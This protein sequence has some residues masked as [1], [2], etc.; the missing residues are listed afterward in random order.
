MKVYYTNPRM[1]KA[2]YILASMSP[3]MVSDVIDLVNTRGRSVI[4]DLADGEGPIKP[5]A[6]FSREYIPDE[7]FPQIFLGMGAIY[8][9][10]LRRL[11]QDNDFYENVL[12][13]TFFIPEDMAAALARKVETID[14]IGGDPKV[15]TVGT[16][17]KLSDALQETIRKAINLVPSILGTNWENDQD[18]QYD[19][20][21]LYEVKTFGT[22]IDDL[23]TRAHLMKSQA[24]LAKS[25]GVF[26]GTQKLY[27]D[28]AEAGG[29]PVDQYEVAMGDIAEQEMG[30]I[31][32][33]SLYG[34][35]AKLIG[36]NIKSFYN[37]A[38]TILHDKASKHSPSHDPA[39]AEALQRHM[40]G[41][42]GNLYHA[43][44][45]IDS[46]D[47]KQALS[48]LN[49]IAKS[50]GIG[51]A[52]SKV[53]ENFGPQVAHH[54][55]MGDIE[56]CIGEI[57]DLAGDAFE[58]TG[59]SDDDEAVIA[60]VLDGLDGEYG[61]AEGSLDAEMGGLFTRARVN[62]KMRAVQRKTRRAG[63]KA[64]RQ[65]VRN[66]RTARLIL[67]KEAKANAG[68][69]GPEDSTSVEEYLDKYRKQGA[70]MEASNPEMNPYF[71]PD[72]RDEG[73]DDYVPTQSY[74]TG[75]SIGGGGDMDQF[76]MDLVNTQ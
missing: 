35:A 16:L 5:Y 46:G 60:S 47:F 74:N 43:K 21:F 76:G 69:Y 37:Q 11:K 9:S 25:M 6:I 75:A 51:D 62:A 28:V 58:S 29:D 41:N 15:S 34:K 12:R 3:D 56:G 39:A 64:A 63:R 18:Q 2:A 65:S 22:V 44:V 55:A 14:V 52:T 57:V 33:W 38:K 42:H 31:L 20:D 27:G 73:G 17:K 67:A 24:L 48:L 30:G 68:Y 32:P 66:A 53:A 54:Y 61:D 26:Q 36:R 1:N 72:T 8:V 40:T 13:T 19:I 45:A 10:Q 49:S 50:A 71:Q 59:N 70:Q 23:I 7:D 4:S